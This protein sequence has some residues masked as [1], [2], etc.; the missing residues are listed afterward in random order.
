MA[1]LKPIRI[2]KNDRDEYAKLARNTKAKINRTVKKYGREAEKIVQDIS[3]PNLTDFKTRAEYNDWKKKAESFTN[4]NNL[5]YQFVKNEYGVVATK[6]QLHKI[7]R[8]TKLAQRLADKQ[9]KEEAKK[10]Y[11]AQGKL[12]ATQAEYK[13]TLMRP[14]M[15][16]YNRP[17]DFNFKQIKSQSRLRTVEESRRKQVD[18]DAYNWRLKKMKEDYLELLAKTFNSDADD[19]IDKLRGIPASDFYEMYKMFEEFDF[20]YF[21]PI[22]GAEGLDHNIQLNLMSVYVDRYYREDINMDL[23]G[24]G[25]SK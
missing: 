7:E 1:R 15:S 14:N 20:D 9:E 18:K 21:Y 22:E 24:V 3:V 5:H 8:D 6:A 13:Q 12:Q 2:T 19:L 17:K 25:G 10:G 16:G 23:K 11:Y 4:R